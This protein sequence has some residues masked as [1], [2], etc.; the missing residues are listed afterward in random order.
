M[1]QPTSRRSSSRSRVA[2]PGFPLL[3]AV[4]P[5]NVPLLSGATLLGLRMD[6]A[7]GSCKQLRFPRHTPRIAAGPLR[8]SFFLFAPASPCITAYIARFKSL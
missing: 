5:T 4:P 1:W 8:H 3:A 2:A 7:V 6:A